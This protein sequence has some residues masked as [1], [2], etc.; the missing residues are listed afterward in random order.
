MTKTALEKA[1][2]STSV[3]YTYDQAYKASLEY[4]R[5]DALAANV[6]VTK[7]ALQDGNNGFLEL[8]PD[9][10]HQRLAREFARIEQKY[11]NPMSYEEIYNLFKNYDEVVA[12]GSPQSA[13]GNPFKVQSTSN[14]FLVAPP[15]DSYSGI[16]MTDQE[17]VQIMK[18][19][20]G[21]GFDI[22]TLRPKGMAT[23]N[24]AGTTDGIEIFM[25]RFSN[26]CREV[27]QCLAEGTLVLT[28]NGLQPIEDISP[29][30]LV[31]TANGWVPVQKVLKNRKLVHK[32][33]THNGY[34]IYASEDHV[35]HTMEGELAVGELGPNSPVSNILGEGWEGFSIEMSLPNMENSGNRLKSYSLPT[36]MT[37]ELAY[38]LGQLYGDGS[39]SV[40]PRVTTS[41]HEL[42]VALSND[43]PTVIDKIRNCVE[44]TFVGITAKIEPGDGDCQRLRISSEQI[45]QYLKVNGFFKVKSQDITFPTQFLSA[46][47]ALLAAFIGGYFDADGYA[48]GAKKGY[49]FSST[50]RDFLQTLKVVLAAHGITSSWHRE[51][52]SAKGWRDL[53]SLSVVGA[54]SQRRFIELLNG[55]S[56]KVKEKNFVAKRD[57]T[58]SIFRSADLGVSYNK[59]SFC[60]D[61]SHLLSRNTVDR[62][63][64]EGVLLPEDSSRLVF[65]RVSSITVAQEENTYDLV[66]DDVH[67]FF[68]NGLY[69][70][71]CGRRGALMLT[72]SVHHPQVRD[73]IN[74]K[75]N[76]TRVTGANISLRL[77][78]EFM[79]A[80]DAGE[81]YRLRWPVDSKEP[82][83]SEMVSA[84][85]IWDLINQAAW[86]SA[87]PGL[88]F[89]DTAKNMT[90]SDIYSDYGFASTSTNPC[91]VG[92]TLIAVADGRNAVSI[93]Q[94]V[95]EG[96]DVPV[97]STNIETGKV[98]IKWGRNPRLTKKNAEVW[99][100]ILDDG[101]YLIA[102]PDHKIMK[103]DCSYVELKDLQSGESVFPF[104]T[105]DSNGYRQVRNTGEN[106]VHQVVNNHKVV[107][108][109][110]YGVE[111][112][113]NIT[114]DDNHNYHVV[115]STEDDKYITSSGL[116]VK[117]CGEIVLS[118]YDS[119]RLMVLNVTT[120]VEHPFTPK[121]K[122]NFKRYVDS[123]IKAQ[124]LMD[125]MIDLELEQVDKI[126]A[127]IEVD[128]EPD[129]VKE[130]ERSL[131]LKIRQAA[132]NGRR[133]G[134]GITGLGDAVA[135][136]N[137]VYGKD[138]SFEF[139]ED[140]YKHLAIG[141]HT[142]S[143]IMAKE[144]G[145]FPVFN[146]DLEKDHVYMKRII[147]ALPEDIQKLYKKH[148]RR[149]IANTTT[150]P[151]GS[152]STQT[153]T[154]S[155]I[156]PAYLIH[157][158]RRKKINPSEA[159][160]KV[161]FVDEL[162]D[163]WQH[164]HVLH[165]GFEQWCVATGRDPKVV[166]Q[167]LYEG[168]T[169]ALKASPYYEATSND[170]SWV[171]KVRIQG[172]AQKWIDHAISNTTNLPKDVTVD[173]VKQVYMEGW[174]SGCK[175]VT[176]YRD[177]C[178]DGVLVSD[179][180]TPKAEDKGFEEHDAP[181]RPLELDCEVHRTRVRHGDDYVDWTIFVGL[182][183]G[184][185]YEI[186][187]GM[188][189][190]IELSNKIES[191]WI[192]KRTLKS[193]ARYD[194]HYGDKDEP[195]VIRDIVK[196]F[197]NPNHGVFTRMLSLSLRHGAAVHHVIEQLQRDKDS[198]LFSFS[199]VMARVLKKYVKDG[200]KSSIRT[201]PDCGSEGTL[202]YQE[203]CVTCTA[204]GSSKC[205]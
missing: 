79:R 55:E 123:V 202:V 113:Y 81:D 159:D 93:R 168:D 8:T 122:F 125:D 17:Q 88:L 106:F 34:E 70:H 51:D 31:W 56:E 64:V 116:C 124:R 201:C 74:I 109:E 52:R 115:T 134:L 84:R 155:G 205:G 179:T 61:N 160:A 9:D 54:S 32:M 156:E 68:A 173:V 130:I 47:K 200:T 80:V 166:A 105:F 13:I 3:L 172:L 21:V 170:I 151:C 132:V 73:F 28:R 53:Y 37:T 174:K 66:L 75:K 148:G 5:G 117:N 18:R 186:F 133:T 107:S 14:C 182:L 78:D 40:V 96:K 129:Y 119:C 29:G 92:D 127:K 16:L 63:R 138:G 20:G 33:V 164:F 95:E 2:Y 180:S 57:C 195:S 36:K 147:D 149:N 150:A 204:C 183:D 6:F 193:S 98:E 26:S 49:T 72:L 7:Y 165:H 71:N 142:S 171:N 143:I 38:F 42:S 11:P 41:N 112:V 22:S 128:P 191:G 102:T 58:L 97:Y 188:S 65:D 192:V 48:S 104:Y 91:I 154:T 45:V 46:D 82:V 19:R 25:D 83:V 62:L 189:E 12:Q 126:L 137:L 120:F 158:T 77:S 100:L 135:M 152:I 187:G 67:L 86:E 140:A 76:R 144:R 121:A 118:N 59:F 197:D 167:A 178:R 43:W 10:M 184:K 87:E 198:D 136:M 24:A 111:D 185:P 175:G 1:N 162:G 153:Q 101:S 90:P 50:S 203:G 114:V 177:G 194:F 146:Y 157:Y 169:S 110:K 103:S 161:D 139:V 199:K 69:A 141:S 60:P 176:V 35:F 108:V 4:F 190:F 44:T 30:S 23:A 94:L 181:R 27:A 131:W 163:K 99:K 145:A 196:T 39:I 85:E 89:W 15:H